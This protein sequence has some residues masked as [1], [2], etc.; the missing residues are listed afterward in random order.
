MLAFPKQAEANILKL[1][2]IDAKITVI[3]VNSLKVHLFVK[4]MINL[5]F[6]YINFY[7]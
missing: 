1:G 5:F 2:V 6:E 4:Q 3:L 7:V